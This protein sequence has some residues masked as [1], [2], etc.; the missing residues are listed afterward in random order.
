VAVEAGRPFRR[1]ALRR[2]DPDP[3]ARPPEVPD[4]LA[5]LS[6]DLANPVPAE[7]TEQPAVEG[8]APLDRGD[9]QIDMMDTTRGAH[10]TLCVRRGRSLPPCTVQL[11][12]YHL[13]TS[14]VRE[15]E[16]RYLGKL[17]FELVARYGRVGEDTTSFERGTS[18]E[19]LDRLDF[20]LRL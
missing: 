3:R 5:A 16:A 18:W 8:Q 14:K 4:R 12:H 19:Q 2:A 13:V 17:G 1:A 9:D 15:V 11:F 20:K 6:L 7:R 10:A